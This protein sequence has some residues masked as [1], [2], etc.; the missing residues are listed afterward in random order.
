MDLFDG[1]LLGNHENGDP[2]WMLTMSILTFDVWRGDVVEEL[3]I[4]L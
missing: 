2:Y 3:I 1:A 4:L